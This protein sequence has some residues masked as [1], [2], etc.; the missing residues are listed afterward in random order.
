MKGK[1]TTIIIL[2]LLALIISSGASA[3]YT[4]N[5]LRLAPTFDIVGTGFSYQGYI[6]KNGSPANGTFNF[7]FRLFNDVSAGG[8]IG[9]TITQSG[10][11]VSDGLFTVIL[12]FGDVFDGTALW[13]EIHVQGPGDPGFTTL[14]PRQPITPTPY[15]INAGKLDGIDSTNFAS[16]THSH[17]E[18]NLV[19][20]TIPGVIF[21]C[22]SGGSCL[23]SQSGFKWGASVTGLSTLAEVQLP[24][25]ATV[26]EFQCYW[27]DNSPGVDVDISILLRRVH[28]NPGG[29]PNQQDLA[30]LTDSTSGTSPFV[31]TDST[32]S[33]S[34]SLIDT[35]NYGYYIWFTMTRTTFP[36]LLDSMI[37]NY[38]CRIKYS[39]NESIQ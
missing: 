24:D 27:Y 26:T 20:V 17:S 2:L 29:V 23:S 39:L 8:Q 21:Q 31:L 36:D 9:S 1:P 25:N 3:D 15:S 13:L 11:V 19:Y 30:S 14:G 16:S 35:Q 10:V 12:D 7:D 28:N 33:I 34:N 5:S 37:R 6:E 4:T 18:S 32:T 38:G 22:M